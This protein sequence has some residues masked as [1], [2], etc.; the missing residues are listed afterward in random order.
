MT[1]FALRFDFRN[2][3]QAGTTMADRYAAALDMAEWA[4]RLGCARITVSEHHGSPDG[5]LPAP[6][7]ML[8]AMAARTT[9]VRF[10]V[11]ALIAPF[12]DPLLLAE[13]MIV[14]DNLGRGRVDL[15]VAGGYVH[16]EF[17]LFDVPMNERAKRV[18]EVVT[19]LKAAFTGEEFTYRGR[20]VRLTPAPFRPGGPS[21][22]LGGSTEPAARRAARIADGFIPSVSEVWEYYR[23]EVLKLGRPDPGPSPIGRNRVVALAEDPDKGWEQMAPFF[24]HETNAYGAWRAQDDLAAP[25][26]S[27][28]G[29]DELRESGQ[30]RVLAPERFV[31]ELK[32]SPRPFTQFHPLRGGMPM[33]LAWSSLR[34]FE[35]EVL[36]AF[37]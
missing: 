20:T 31:A 16:E 33:E 8:A 35:H 29:T 32:S 18:T 34:L 13:E 14:L 30:Y 5:Y 17:A 27:V 6:I 15:V 21:V 1:A 12:H 25:F 26:R 11:A 4:D 7:P 36:P 3:E 37:T 22:S 2:P 28:T 24:L 19:T 23:D 9:N 10:L